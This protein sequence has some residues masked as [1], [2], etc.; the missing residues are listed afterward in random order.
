MQVQERLNFDVR[1]NPIR[2]PKHYIKIKQNATVYV[3]LKATQLLTQR[4]EFCR[5]TLVLKLLA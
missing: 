2:S 3:E 1:L 5:N 4:F